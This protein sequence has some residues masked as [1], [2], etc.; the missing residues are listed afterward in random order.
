MKAVKQQ[1]I[2][3]SR[4]KQALLIYAAD[5]LI[6]F[7]TIAEINCKC[8]DRGIFYSVH[9]VARATYHLPLRSGRWLLWANGSYC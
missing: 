3:S 5:F 6:I 2:C 7:Q 9:P 4:T 8:T 1:Q